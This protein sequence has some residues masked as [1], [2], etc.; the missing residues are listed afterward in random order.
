MH[1]SPTSPQQ[2]QVSLA[3]QK[4]HHLSSSYSVFPEHFRRANCDFQ[5]WQDRAVTVVLRQVL[6]SQGLRHRVHRP[7]SCR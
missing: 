4:N 5:H 1:T 2:Q 7:T 3:T 6:D